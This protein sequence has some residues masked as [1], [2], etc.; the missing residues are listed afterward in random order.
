MIVAQITDLHIKPHG[1]LAYRMVDTAEHLRRAVAFLNR[2]DPRPDVV[3]AT[4]D[5]VDAG[6]ADEYTRLAELL[7][8]LAMPYLLV[9]GNHD[10]R[11]TLRAAFPTHSWLM[12]HD[13]FIQY[14]VE[15]HALRLIG[16]DTTE[17]ERIGGI[18]CDRRLAWLDDQLSR[19]ARPT[20]LFM[21]HPPFATGM[22]Y[23]DGDRVENRDAFAAV[24]RRHPHVK[25]V[26]CG[27]VHRAISVHWAGTPMSA[28][29]STAHQLVLNLG[30]DTD[31]Q[32]AMEPPACQ[33]LV[34][35]PEGIVAHVCPIGEFDGPYPIF[36]ADG[37]LVD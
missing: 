31:L 3:L 6:R 30:R 23:H 37:T 34:A 29:S 27:H 18:L 15:D 9:P 33:I 19:S 36:E 17:P 32:F 13:G 24:L 2:L 4:G 25:W 35:G 5:L 21:H 1:R 7:A 8:P 11:E 20:I 22:P 28:V 14:A 16:L 26:L 10:C 12:G